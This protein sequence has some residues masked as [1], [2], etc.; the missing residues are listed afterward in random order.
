MSL[1]YGFY[2][3]IAGDRKYNTVQM[4]NLFDGI[5][6][7]GVFMSIG[8]A[9]HVSATTGMGITIGLGR[10]WFNHTWTNNDAPIPLT[11]DPSELVLNRI[12]MIVLEVNANDETRTNTIKMV[13]GTPGSFPVA[14]V[15]IRTELVNQYSLAEIYV[16]HGVTSILQANITNK[17][18]TTTCPYVTG[19]LETINIDTLVAQWNSQFTIWNT[20]LDTTFDTW[21]ANIQS[22]YTSWRS[23]LNSEFSTWFSSVESEFNT[24]FAATGLDYTTWKTGL[25]S[26]FSTW[27]A[28]LRSVLDTNQA[29]N[30]LGLINDNTA[31]IALKANKIVVDDIT[32][33]HY[34]MGI[35][36]GLLYYKAVV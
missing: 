33:A 10:A 6:K 9:L 8:D 17:I 14:P 31:S 12:D 7:D 35:S 5:I 23:G 36:N 30:L 2:N 24:W 15:C 28:N 26:E 1:T 34:Q 4:S 13:K 27:F 25:D 20:G 3:S 21:F 11:I 32:S 19:V 22:E 16:G 29:A 18:G